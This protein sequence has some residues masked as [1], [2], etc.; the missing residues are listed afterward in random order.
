VKVGGGGDLHNMDAF[1][2]ML[3][4]SIVLICHNL[5]DFTRVAEPIKPYFWPSVVLA[6]VIPITLSLGAVAPVSYDDKGANEV[7]KIMDALVTGVTSHG[8]KV[9]F[10]TQRHLLTFGMIKD[11]PLIPEYEILTLNEMALS[12]N[13]KY[14]SKFYQ[15]LNEH[16]YD[17]IIADFQFGIL[18]QQEYAFGRENDLWTLNAGRYLT[19]EYIPFLTFKEYNIQLFLPKINNPTCP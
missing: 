18:K 15:D 7:L 5:V 6:A 9:L 10:I 8:G 4:V 2:V 17:L 3:A 12:N 1:M 14:L 19:C 13:E 11:V 16:I